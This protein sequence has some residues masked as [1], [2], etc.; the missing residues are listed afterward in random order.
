[1]KRLLAM[2][3][4]LTFIAA[5]A[6]TADADPIMDARA[7]ATI[8]AS[9]Y[10]ATGW[11]AMAFGASVVLS[12]LLGGGTVIVLANVLRPDVELP[13]ARMADAQKTY[14]SGNDLMLYHSQYQESMER[15]V[16][17]DRS[18]RAWIGAGIGLA[19]NFVIILAI[20]GI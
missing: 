8:D 3:L 5:T 9:G 14:E 10:R 7:H 11:G 17:K 19:V 12:P 1:M 2:V 4:I 20:L 15:P 6:S 16:Q 13:T 18:R